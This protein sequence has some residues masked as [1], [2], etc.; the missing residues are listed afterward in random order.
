MFALNTFLFHYNHLY[1]FQLLFLFCD[2]TKLG[3]T[4]LST[5]T[6]HVL[7]LDQLPESQSVLPTDDAI[8]SELEPIAKEIHLLE[9]I[10]SAV[11]E[12]LEMSSGKN[13]DKVAVFYKGSSIA[14][15]FNTIM[16]K[17]DFQFNWK[18]VHFP[19]I[20]R[21][22]AVLIGINEYASYTSYPLQGCVSDVRLMEQYLAE[23]LSVP[24]NHIRWLLGSKEH[25][26]PGDL[27]QI[28]VHW[29][30][31]CT[32]H[33]IIHNPEILYG[34]NI[35]I[36]YSG[37]GLYYLI[38]EQGDE[39][40]YIEAL[41][42]IDHDISGTDGK[43]IPDISDQELN[44]ILTQISQVKG[45]E[46]YVYRILGYYANARPLWE[47]LFGE[48]WLLPRLTQWLDLWEYFYSYTATRP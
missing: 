13:V 29:I 7:L 9:E 4:V 17:T 45:S 28:S 30:I 34:N 6:R 20:S 35:I 18:S 27:N 26:S 25:T 32:L 39:T 44:T 16:F 23:D 10:E 46:S 3:T 47:I 8:L 40:E 5:A 15:V 12:K 22:Y 11:A 33:I 48:S 42:P 14:S 21:F 36:Y 19:Q 31:R 1:R 24:H 43:P 38:E 2:A 37:H 41:C